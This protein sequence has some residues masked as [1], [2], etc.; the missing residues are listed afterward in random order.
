MTL[1]WRQLERE[2]YLLKTSHKNVRHFLMWSDRT[3]RWNTVYD[4]ISDKN[5]RLQATAGVYGQSMLVNTNSHSSPAT[6]L[7]IYSKTSFAILATQISLPRP[8]W[9]LHSPPGASNHNEAKL[10]PVVSWFFN[11]EVGMRVRLL[12]L[13]SMPG[14]S[15]E[16]I[17]SLFSHLISE[18]N[19][20]LR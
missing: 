10:F 3:N 13:R 15:S 9:R 6:V 14:E 18:N 5:T 1:P 12:D 11:A 20:D 8:E 2:L 7:R 17:K 4:S 16:Q 19:L